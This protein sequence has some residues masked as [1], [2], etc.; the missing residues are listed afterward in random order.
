VGRAKVLHFFTLDVTI[1]IGHKYD[2]FTSKLPRSYGGRE[3]S[4]EGNMRTGVVI[5]GFKM[6]LVLGVNC[7]EM[8]FSA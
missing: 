6:L 4:K 7:L 3:V 8:D 2:G 5:L 1:H